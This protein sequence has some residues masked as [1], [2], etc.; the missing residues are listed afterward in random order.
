M[1]LLA[2]YL[3]FPG[4]IKAQTPTFPLCESQTSNG[5]PHYDTGFHQIAGDGLL[6]GKD[7]V[8]GLGDNY[9]FQCFCSPT[10]SGIQ[11]N[12]TPVSE[13]AEW[14]P[15]WGLNE[16]DYNYENREYNCGSPVFPLCE[17]QTQNGDRAHYDTG[18][19]QIAGDGLLEG[20]DDVY[21]LSKSYFFQCFCSPEGNGIQTNWTPDEEGSEPGSKWGLN[22]INYNYENRNYNCGSV[23]PTPTPTDSHENSGG[24]SPPVCNDTIPSTPRVLS[25]TSTGTNSVKIM[26]TKVTQANSYSILYGRTSGEYLYSVFSTGDTDNFVIN[27]IS[28]GC[29]EVK[30]V[31]GCMPGP[32][33]AEFCTGGSV[34]GAS[35]LGGTGTFT[36][37]VNKIILIFGLTLTGFGLIKLAKKTVSGNNIT[38][39]VSNMSIQESISENIIAPKTGTMPEAF[40]LVA[41]ERATISLNYLT[42][43][44]YYTDLNRSEDKNLF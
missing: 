26:W 25:V 13:G 3:V 9:Y 5:N 42:P 32:L 14:G 4:N 35:T 24:G 6:E 27:G 7:D 29:F 39:D 23:N 16:T 30:A 15:D 1:L 41:I 18:L 31:N 34:L 33:S 10:G 40:T 21:S 19:H 20:K 44:S 2:G 43:S 38:S 8:Y 17:N 37:S 22:D 12:W 28:S 11:T 36:D